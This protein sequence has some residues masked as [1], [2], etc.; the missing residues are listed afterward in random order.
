MKVGDAQLVI[1]QKGCPPYARAI[2]AGAIGAPQIAQKQQPIGLDEDAM[3]LRDALVVE[4]KIA[5][6]LPADEH[7]FLDDLHGGA[8]FQRYELCTHGRSVKTSASRVSARG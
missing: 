5:I 7:H 1:G 6:F 8:A 4:P 2:D 3:H